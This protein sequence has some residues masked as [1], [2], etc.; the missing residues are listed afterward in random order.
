MSTGKSLR[1]EAAYFR[2]LKEPLSYDIEP[3]N[4]LPVVPGP[5]ENVRLHYSR[6][7]RVEY[8]L[9]TRS[10]A[11]SCCSGEMEILRSE[12]VC[13]VGDRFYILRI[14]FSYG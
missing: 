12:I 3:K 11:A 13:G 10:A 5:D 8:W 1:S 14:G 9:R 6:A 4:P 7:L 2:L